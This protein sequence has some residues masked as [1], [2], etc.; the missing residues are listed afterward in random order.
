MHRALGVIKAV[1]RVIP[2]GFHSE[3]HTRLIN[4]MLQGQAITESLREIEGKRVSI[5][6]RDTGNELIFRLRHGQLIPLRG[7]RSAHD[8]DVRI[9]GDLLGFWLL[10][11]RAEDPDTL[12][13][14]RQLALE[15]ETATGLYIKNL[16][17]GLDFDPQAHLTAVF[18]E[19]IG[20]RIY[21]ILQRSGID[22][23]LRQRMG[24]PSAGY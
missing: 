7:R 20:E 21:R 22:S 17:D 16:L 6:I 15:G 11:T 1:M 19:R 10:T 2:D 24:L 5:F 13:F 23:R 9:S 8:W 18:G 12:F 4:H 3:L 14:N